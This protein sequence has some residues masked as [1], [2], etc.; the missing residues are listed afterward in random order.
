M[1]IRADARS[2][3]PR[4]G[5]RTWGVLGASTVNSIGTGLTMPFVLIYLHSVRGM[6]LATAGE[7][8][9]TDGAVGLVFAPAAGRL[10]DRLGGGRAFA[11]ALTLNGFTTAGYALVTRPWHAFV[12]AILLGIASPLLWSSFASL[13]SAVTP[14]SQLGRAFGVSYA[15][16]NL[17]IGLGG[18]V[19]GF[20]LS[21]SS[22]RS[23]EAIFLADGAT[24]LFYVGVLAAIGELGTRA[25]AASVDDE[26]PSEGGAGGGY[27]AVLADRAL[28]AIT[29]I[30]GLLML[31]GFSQM[32]SAFPAWTVGP[33]GAPAGVV[34]FAFAANTVTVVVAQ[35]F[36]LRL[37]AGRRRTSAAAVGSF[38]FVLAWVM[39][40]LAAEAHEVTVTSVVLVLSFVVIGLGETILSP[41]FAPLV[42]LLAPSALRGRYNA[43]YGYASQIGTAVGPLIAG[44]ALGH[45]LG[46]P[47]FVA[48]AAVCALAGI[49]ASL[50]ARLVPEEVNRE[51]PEL[52]AEP[53]PAAG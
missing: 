31:A 6:D 41:T 1:Q 24:Y 35:L 45:G 47:Y 16:T 4:L 51:A 18:L 3:I 25:P 5:S 11:V 42:N 15:L 37:F 21:T 32:T 50:A 46:R 38:A 39:T 29:G 40:L 33:A 7:V 10:V 26:E 19:A 28:L 48:L 8:L 27:R 44:V 30:Y 36:V 2:L 34:G 22:V 12:V 49:L 9:A 53:A 52:E 43:V 20:A 14:A 23:F 13:L 17:G